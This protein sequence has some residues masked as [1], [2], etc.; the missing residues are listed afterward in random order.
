MKVTRDVVKDLL[1]V[2]LSGEATADTRA[3][4]E[5]YLETDPNLARE[6]ETARARDLELPETPAP[7]AAAERQ[8]LETTRQLLKNRTSTLV[9]ATV[10]TLL[11]FA[12]TFEGS[13]ITFLLI[14]DA[15]I[16]GFTW[17]ATAA[18]MWIWH[19]RI[20]RRLRVSGL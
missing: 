11:P 2:Y 6:V 10:F 19:I 8:A 14:R 1:T 4:V 13:R 7:T 15:P 17:W 9:V 18:V 12:F 3:F 20:R 5:Q 16:I